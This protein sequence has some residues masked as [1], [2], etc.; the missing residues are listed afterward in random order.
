MNGGARPRVGTGG[1]TSLGNQLRLDGG[2][3]PQAY[4][5]VFR[6]FRRL[7]IPGFLD[8]DS[9]AGLYRS[10]ALSRGWLRTIHVDKGQDAEIVLDAE[11]APSPQARAVLERQLMGMARDSFRYIFDLIRVSADVR[12]GRQVDPALAAAFA[13]V[14]SAPFLDFV[15][16]LTGE[17]DLAY[18]D[19]TATRYR[20]GDF[21]TVHDDEAPEQHRRFAYVLNLTPKWRADW[22]GILMFLDDEDHVAE[23]YVPAFN[24]LNIFEV[25]QRHSVSMVAPFA[26]GERI[27]LT[28]WIRSRAPADGES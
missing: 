11:D 3:R 15:R 10:V 27:S 4:R 25:P 22:G 2:L 5:P 8:P 9:A 1:E 18:C 26:E 6:Q 19:M 16:T 23:G 21:L 7:H 24:A 17:P 12:A 28:G 20:G 13:F 14:N